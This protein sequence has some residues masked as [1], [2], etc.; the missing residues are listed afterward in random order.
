MI[1][2]ER[3]EDIDV[4]VLKSVMLLIVDPYKFADVKSQPENV[5]PVISVADKSIEFKSRLLYLV[6]APTITTVIKSTVV[7]VKFAVAAIVDVMVTVPIPF[8]VTVPVFAEFVTVIIPA[9]PGDECVTLK[10]EV[11]VLDVIIDELG[12]E[13]VLFIIYF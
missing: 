10:E 12:I 1:R 5:V 11:S 2:P 9:F 7:S 4:T 13:N 8:T 3:S 6:P